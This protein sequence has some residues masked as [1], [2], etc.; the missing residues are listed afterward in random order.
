[1]TGTGRCGSPNV[2][3]LLPAAVGQ[4]RGGPDHDSAR[5]GRSKRLLCGEWTTNCAA[6]QQME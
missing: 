3:Y 4:H 5:G 6:G 2:A 1:M